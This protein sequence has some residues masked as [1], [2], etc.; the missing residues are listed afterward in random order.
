[1]NRLARAGS[2]A[3]AFN[4]NQDVIFD[5]KAV[6]RELNNLQPGLRKELVRDLK[7]VAEPMVIDVKSVIPTTSP[8]SGMSSYPVASSRG[9]MNSNPTGRTAWERG[10]YGTKGTVVAPNNVVARFSS[11][12]SRRATVTS[13]FSVWARSP[14]V[15]MAGVAG[16]GTGTPRYAV[17]KEYPYKTGVRRHRNNGQGQALIRRVRN[18]GL[19]NFFY[20]AAEKSQPDV[21][22]EVKL[23]WESYAKRVERR[24][25]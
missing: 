2:R 7:K 16:K 25:K 12:R 14:A 11:G 15:S 22:R 13:L 5:A 19:F 18:E 23:V 20:R 24:I 21:E 8:F 3:S 10:R 17:T 6:L 9:G 4:Q 1:M